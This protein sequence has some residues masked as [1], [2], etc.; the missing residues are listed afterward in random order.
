MTV[1]SAQSIRERVDIGQKTEEAAALGK[2]YTSEVWGSNGSKRILPMLIEPFSE[3]KQACGMSYGLTGAGYDIRVGK[4]DRTH[5]DHL[6]RQSKSYL[7]KHSSTAKETMQSW[8][9]QP[10][11]FMLAASL[12]RF[13]LPNDIQAIVH[14]KSTLA[15]QGLALQNTVLEPGWEGYITLELSNHG[16]KPIRVLVGQPIAQVV[17][18]V[19]DRPTE[20]PYRGKYQNQ[21]NLPTPAKFVG[22][23]NV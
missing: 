15:R 3:A 12:E 5:A 14:D 23:D 13:K 16:S 9:L 19:L 2:R 4:L 6:T 20:I 8:N 17:F 7:V 11:E 10:G 1:L 22:E 21:D 18:H